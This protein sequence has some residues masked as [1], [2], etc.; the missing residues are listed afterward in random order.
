MV[1]AL[2]TGS[3][4]PEAVAVFER[5]E[6]RVEVSAYYPGSADLDGIVA[7]LAK[8]SPKAATGPISIESVSDED[9]VTLSQGLRPPVRAGRFLVHGSHDR[10]SLARARLAIEIDASQAFGTAHHA[11]TRGCLLALDHVLKRKRPSRVLDLGT[12]SGIL[13]IAA[14]KALGRSALASDSDLTAVSIAR[15]NARKNRVAPFVRVIVAN[16]FAHPRLRRIKPELVFANLLAQA[17]DDLA[18]DMA[19]RIAP[20]GIAILSGLTADQAR[21][22]VA[23]YHAFGFRMEKR[24]VLDGWATLLLVRCKS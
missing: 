8:T 6:G 13:A 1:G 22:T 12:G 3:P 20:G 24:I 5:P 21:G 19:R 7:R 23:R 14:A 4:E 15:A 11:S 9:W 18:P 16:G 2:E 10:N 17:L